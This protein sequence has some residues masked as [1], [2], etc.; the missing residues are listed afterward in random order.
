LKRRELVQELE[1]AGCRLVRRGRRHD[2]YEN[3]HTK[4][5]APVPRHDEIAD[6][7]ARM[8]KKQLGL[9]G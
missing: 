4:R 6:S 5:R 2:I 8:I 3:P 1:E 7:L 9:A